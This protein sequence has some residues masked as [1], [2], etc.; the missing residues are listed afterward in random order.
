MEPWLPRL[1]SPWVAAGVLP[2]EGDGIWFRRSDHDHFQANSAART[3]LAEVAAALG[4][5]AETGEERGPRQCP[6][7]H[8]T[9]TVSWDGDITLC[10]WDVRVENK[11]GEVTSDRLSRVWR[12][13]ETLAALRRST[14]GRG[15]PDRDLCR[16]C[17]QPYSPNYRLENPKT[18]SIP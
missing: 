4:I 6:G 7:V 15:V 10:P 14:R 18:S 12:E 13:D 3:R 17:H 11:V 9:P 16:D 2:G 1:R 8:A 5:P